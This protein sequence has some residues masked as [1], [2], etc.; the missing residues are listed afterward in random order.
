VN[1]AS[2]FTIS[3]YESSEFI[4]TC[5]DSVAALPALAGCNEHQRETKIS[6]E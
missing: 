6:A 2:R 1:K 5:C 4:F 3:R